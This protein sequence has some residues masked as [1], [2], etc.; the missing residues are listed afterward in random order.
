MAAAS[1]ALLLAGCQGMPYPLASGQVRSAA[2]SVAHE[3]E[4]AGLTQPAVQPA[5][6][7]PVLQQRLTAPEGREAN[8]VVARP[9]GEL[10]MF[11]FTGDQPE[12]AESAREGYE[13][14]FRLFPEYAQSS[15]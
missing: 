9:Q 12:D 3:A 6:A 13:I 10:L 11:V 7:E 14:R 1:A 5:V 8:A 2:G 4:P 15:E